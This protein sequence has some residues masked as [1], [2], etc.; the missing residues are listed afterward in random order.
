MGINGLKPLILKY[1]P[2]A[3]RCSGFTLKDLN[4]QL[5]AIDASI[6]IYKYLF[7]E[8]FGPG[9]SDMERIVISMCDDALFFMMKGI[10]PVYI[11][12]GKPPETK[13]YT[14]NKRENCRE[15]YTQE[16]SQLSDDNASI[17]AGPDTQRQIEK[18]TERIMSLQKRSK[19][20]TPEIRDTIKRVFDLLG[21]PN[22]K[23]NG[24]AE[25]LCAYLNKTGAVAACISNDTDL[26]ALGAPLLILP[27]SR[28]KPVV[29]SYKYSDILAGMGLTSAQ[30]RDVCILCGCDYIPDVTCKIKG[31]GPI[32]AYTSIH[33]YGSIEGV[34]K[35]TLSGGETLP[36][37]FMAYTADAR[38]NFTNREYTNTD[39]LKEA[40]KVNISVPGLK[41]VLKD[42]TNQRKIAKITDTV[43]YL[44]S[45]MSVAHK[46]VKTTHTQT[47]P[48]TQPQTLTQPVVKVAPK[49]TVIKPPAVLN[50]KKSRLRMKSKAS[51]DNKNNSKKIQQK[52]ELKREKKKE[53]KKI[54]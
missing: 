2:N 37:N 38:A 9:V 51:L 30:F 8:V 48:Q 32:R 14:L 36:A 39:M 23:A 41:T 4:G 22:I 16:I 27:F 5:V 40:L 7:S 47:Q 31:M 19:R 20:V 28:T 35:N 21:V 52:K 42:I 45:K 10:T 1:A 24:E 53:M 15:K 13:V 44:Q 6:Y 18:N 50:D 17:L 34:I 54:K 3:I 12:D 43:E 46:T 11:F 26:I 29:T 33:K 49:P 25:V